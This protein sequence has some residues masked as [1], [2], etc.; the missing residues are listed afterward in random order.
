MPF[1]LTNT[2]TTFMTLMISSFYKY[3]RRFVLVFMDDNFIYSKSRTEHLDHFKDYICNIEKQPIIC[4][5]W[6]NANFVY[7]R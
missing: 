3:L 2:L 5:K 7:P 6:A 1:G 4:Q